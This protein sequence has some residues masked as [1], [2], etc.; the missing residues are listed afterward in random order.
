MIANYG[1]KDGSGEF[2]IGIDTDKCIDCT[3]RGCL[4]AC[5]GSIFEVMVDDWDDEVVSLRKKNAI[6]SN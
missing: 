5:P 2:Y 3:D 1:F 6:K 4:T